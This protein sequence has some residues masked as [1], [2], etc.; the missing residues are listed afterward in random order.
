MS[1]YEPDDNLYDKV[2]D[3]F[4]AEKNKA[5]HIKDEDLLE[6]I[7]A[8]KTVL[9]TSGGRKFVWWILSQ[10]NI[11]A[12]LYLGRALDDAFEKG[13]RSV[14]T[15]ILSLCLKADPMILHKMVEEKLIPNKK[16]EDQ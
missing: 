5:K 12:T 14:A 11:F 6:L 13:Q 2:D 4:K 8:A 10:Y 3:L 1:D 15:E 16:E 7:Y 9:G